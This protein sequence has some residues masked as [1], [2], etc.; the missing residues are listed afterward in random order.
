MFRRPV[1]NPIRPS[2]L[3]RRNRTSTSSANVGVTHAANDQVLEVR[4]ECPVHNSKEDLGEDLEKD[5]EKD[6]K[7]DLEEN[8]EEDLEEDPDGEEDWEFHV[9]IFVLVNICLCF[10]M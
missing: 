4:F 7:E 5:P 3:L 9:V 10:S 1:R 2:P 8:L 6:S